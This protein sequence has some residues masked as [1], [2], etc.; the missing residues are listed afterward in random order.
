L[1]RRT[2]RRY[3]GERFYRAVLPGLE[4]DLPL[5]EIE[6]GLWI[7]SDVELILGDVEL[8]SRSALLLSEKVKSFNPEVVLTAE[9][10]SIALAY[11]L[12]R[13]LGHGRFVVARKTL[14]AYTGDHISQE[15]KSITTRSEQ[16]LLLTKEGMGRISGKRVCLLDDV[17]ST[18]ATFKALE[19][20]TKKA[21]GDVVCRAAIWKE[22]PW[23]DQENLVYLDLLPVF[24][25]DA[26]KLSK[27]IRG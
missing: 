7:A 13:L 4:R 16:R 5:V 14:K 23:Y 25:S 21:A 22:G 18:G 3:A 12:S 1:E 9:A 15:V 17:V 26:N 6:A 10:K 8:L 24:V 27:L 2:V 19:A 11:E 20:I